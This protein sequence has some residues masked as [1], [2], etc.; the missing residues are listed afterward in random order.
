MP[1]TTTNKYGILILMIIELMA[2]ET[3]IHQKRE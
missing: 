1:T 2:P 3:I